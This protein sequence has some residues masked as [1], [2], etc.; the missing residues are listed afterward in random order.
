ML[1][2]YIISWVL[3]TGTIRYALLQIYNESAW[4]PEAG[5]LRNP[6]QLVF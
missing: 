5:I 6:Q 2:I 3:A 1:H 4:K